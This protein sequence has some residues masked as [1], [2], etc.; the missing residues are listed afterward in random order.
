MIHLC[1]ISA[2]YGGQAV[3]QNINLHFETGNIY[4]IIGK[5]GCGKSTLLKVASGLLVPYTGKVL[6]GQSSLSVL[7][8][9]QR[10]QRIAVLPQM[11]DVPQITVHSLVMH[12]RFPYLGFPRNPSPKDKEIVEQCMAQMGVTAYRNNS[13]RA[14]SGG[15]RQKVY[16]A[17]MLAQ[18]ADVLLLDEPTTYLDINHQLDLLDLLVML[19]NEG[20]TIVMVMHDIA[21]ALQYSDVVC[22]MEHGRIATVGTPEQIYKSG[23]IQSVFHINCEI[24]SSPDGKTQAYVMR[25]TQEQL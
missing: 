11:R 3:I 20:K 2:G 4:S 6:L 9:K 8:A 19:R 10:A 7:S 14:L 13:I 22:V 5:N 25:R 24:A 12:G 21:H 16:L 17:M 1:D 18:Q 23:K 15:E